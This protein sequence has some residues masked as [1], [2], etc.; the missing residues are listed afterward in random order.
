MKE[1]DTLQNPSI[2][3]EEEKKVEYK[4]SLTEDIAIGTLIFLTGSF[5][6]NFILMMTFNINVS[7]YYEAKDYIASSSNVLA[8]L[9]V[10][11][12]FGIVLVFIEEKTKKKFKIEQSKIKIFISINDG[13]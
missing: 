10:S 5:L 7:N 6:N 9:A 11:I 13:V 1:A 8:L 3:N 12:L 2:K 4:R